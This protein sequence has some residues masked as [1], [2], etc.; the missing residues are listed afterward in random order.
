MSSAFFTI[1]ARGFPMNSA[2]HSTPAWNKP[3]LEK[4]GTL[5]DVAGPRG[6]G[7]EGGPNAKS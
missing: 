6:S 5:K 2:N 1:L 4:L 3:T 7:T